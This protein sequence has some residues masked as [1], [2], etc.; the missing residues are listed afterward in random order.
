MFRTPPHG[1]NSHFTYRP[2]WTVLEVYNLQ[3][4]VLFENNC[5]QNLRKIFDFK[6][7][8]AKEVY[9]AFLIKK[10]STARDFRSFRLLRETTLDLDYFVLCRLHSSFYPH[11][12]KS[13]LRP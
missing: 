6:F 10:Y 11:P 5:N 1:K 3:N 2:T 4:R 9:V 8:V 13:W 12:A 7:I